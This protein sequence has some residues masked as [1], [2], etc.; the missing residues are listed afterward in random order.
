MKSE[1]PDPGWT[2]VSTESTQN[3]VRLPDRIGEF[4]IVRRLGAG[5]MGIVYEAEQQQPKRPVAL[6][7]IRGGAYVDEHGGPA[8]C[9]EPERTWRGRPGSWNPRPIGGPPTSP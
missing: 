7:V 1:H 3:A 2:F 5:G 6:K 8:I 4:R 9:H